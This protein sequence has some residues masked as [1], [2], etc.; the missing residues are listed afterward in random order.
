VILPL[1]GQLVR[2]VR[3]VADVEDSTEVVAAGLCSWMR[4]AV[5]SAR[6]KHVRVDDKQPA[7]PFW[8]R[9]RLPRP[10]A[11]LLVGREKP[12]LLLE[13]DIV[14]IGRPGTEG[15]IGGDLG[16]VDLAV[17][18]GTAR[19]PVQGDIGRGEGFSAIAAWIAS[20]SNELWVSITTR[21]E[22]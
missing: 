5:A 12:V 17:T 2:Q 3:S 19:E 21:T 6:A 13:G 16:G 11:R 1:I 9:P 14:E 8:T 10:A 4:G 20:K 18:S 22:R 15:P 7:G